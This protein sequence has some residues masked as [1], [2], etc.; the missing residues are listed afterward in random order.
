MKEMRTELRTVRGLGSA[1]A[2]TTHFW[3]VRVSGL[4]LVPLSLFAIGLVFSLI[5][6]DQ[7]AVQ[8]V[9][10]RPVV[11]IAMI[12]F[13]VI[14][15]EH[16]RLGIQES[17]ADYVHGDLLKVV[18]LILNTAFCLLVGAAAVFSL[19]IIAFGA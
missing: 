14:G 4:A 7:A 13:V 15:V 5:G 11:T 18:T 10:A 8:A 2:G 12:L 6:K 3:I 19:L 9:L 16:M 1:H 17:I